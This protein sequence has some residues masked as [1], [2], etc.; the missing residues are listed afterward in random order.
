MAKQNEYIYLAVRDWELGQLNI[1]GKLTRGDGWFEFV[2]C[3][4]YAKLRAEGW[5]G[6]FAFRE[7]KVYRSPRLFPTFSRRLPHPKRPDIQK[8]LQRY[9]L[10]TYDGFNLLRNCGTRIPTDNLEFLD[11]RNL[12]DNVGAPI[13]APVG[14]A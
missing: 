14:E 1:I 4:D 11:P 3:G 7:E 9:G 5:P 12:P 10:E 6:L 8:I 2:Y 13:E